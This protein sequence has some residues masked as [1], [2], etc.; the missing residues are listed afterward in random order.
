LSYSLDTEIGRFNFNTVWTHFLKREDERYDGA[1]ATFQLADLSG[2][3]IDDTSYASDKASFNVSYDWEDLNIVYRATYISGLEYNAADFQWGFDPAEVE[4]LVAEVD[5]FLY[6]DISA[7]YNF[8][9]NSIVSVGIDNVTNELPPYIENGFNANT[10]ESTYRLFG[11]GYFV[12][13]TQ[14][15]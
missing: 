11:R 1:T 13:F 8:S 5:S 14:K 10:D 15:F 7:T 2:R 12:K 3:F 4:G 9:T 6:H